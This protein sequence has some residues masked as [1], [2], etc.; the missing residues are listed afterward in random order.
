MDSPNN[1]TEAA[2]LINFSASSLIV[3]SLVAL[4]GALLLVKFVQRAR[5]KLP[6]GPFAWPIVGNFL[7]LR[8]G[9]TPQTLAVVSKKYGDICL[10]QMG[11]RKVLVISSP[12]MAK[13]ILQ[14]Q[15]VEFGSRARN[16][17]FDMTTG[18]GQDLVFADYGE[19]WRK[20]RRIATLPF[21]TNKVVQQSRLAWEEEIGQAI[22][23]ISAMPGSTTSGIIIRD[24]LQLM[25][26]NIVYHMMFR[27]R[28]SGLDDPLYVQL[29]KHNRDNHHL[30]QSFKYNYGDFVP[31]FKPF[32][33]GY[34]KDV[35][36]ANQRR[37]AFLR[38]AFL[39]ER[40][41]Q[42][43]EKIGVDFFL[44]AHLKGEISESSVLYL[45]Q[46]MNVAAIETTLWSTEWGVAE[47]VNNPRIQRKIID[48][49]D[50]VLGKGVPL[51]EPDLPRLPYLQ[52]MVKEILRVH[53]VIPMLLPHMNLEAVKLAGYDIPAGCR[54]LVNAWGIANDPRY[55]DKPEIFNPDRFL[56][57]N[58]EPNGNDFRFIPFGSGRRSCPGSMIA[59]PV[60]G[61]VLGKL[62][63]AF[64]LL[65]PPGADKVDLRSVGGQLSLTIAKRSKVVVKPRGM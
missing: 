41:K 27:R 32:L 40:R 47:L 48:E 17:V 8:S 16:L 25:M 42:T 6:P 59:V 30:A 21:F 36:A 63:Q 60:L 13:E 45:V 35:W 52:A 57:N 1:V 62:L 53:M 44:D 14:T 19:H 24:R 2:P 18:H 5:V 56:D 54:V 28:F 61:L 20:M 49:L 43:G 11:Q 22:A 4:I 37:L 31:S 29:M 33:R 65:P 34:L 7:Q 46:N 3:T 9:L 10:L 64:E 58:I 38:D 26:Y 50:N 15:G 51:T 12:D 23:E 55:W 39:N